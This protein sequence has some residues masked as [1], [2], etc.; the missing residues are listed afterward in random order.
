MASVN[1]T[2]SLHFHSSASTSIF[3]DNKLP[4]CID[5]SNTQ[6]TSSSLNQANIQN[7][8]HSNMRFPHLVVIAL[9]LNGAL[10]APSYELNLVQRSEFAVA[11]TEAVEKFCMINKCTGV[12]TGGPKC[13]VD[14]KSSPLTTPLPSQLFFTQ[15]PFVIKK[16][17]RN[18]DTRMNRMYDH[19]NVQRF[20][21]RLPVLQQNK[22][23]HEGV[24][25]CWYYFIGCQSGEFSQSCNPH[26]HISSF[27]HSNERSGQCKTTSRAST[28]R[29]GLE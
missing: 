8:N 20:D 18:A 5:P 21:V 9:S 7:F 26:H 12:S 13:N 22:Y 16:T 2:K 1:G 17:V 27:P 19:S 29:T 4:L 15:T 10:A 3:L 6:P 11:Q 23:I 25:C 14:R 24:L 28:T